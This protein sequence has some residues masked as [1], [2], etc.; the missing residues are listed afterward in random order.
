MRRTEVSVGCVALAVL[1]LGVAS[2]AASTSAWVVK[3]N[4]TCRV[5]QQR[6]AA[7]FGTNPA[8]PS[9][10]AGMYAFAV[11][12]RPIEVGELHALQAIRLTR[13]PGATKALSYVVADIAELDAAIAAYRAGNKARFLERAFAW[14]TDRR[15]SRA[16]KAIGATACV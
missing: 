5:W 15:A 12:A 3:A 2:A 11:K 9:T 7:L 14:Q 16:F 8:E 4:A 6:S 10:T 13:P 1:A